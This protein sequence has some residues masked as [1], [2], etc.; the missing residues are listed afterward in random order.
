VVTYRTA[1]RAAGGAT[2]AGSIAEH[3]RVGDDG[4]RAS[5]ADLVAPA[6]RTSE[7][8]VVAAKAWLAAS[9]EG[10]WSGQYEC[11][12]DSLP[13]GTEI[14]PGDAVRVVV[15]SRSAQ[16]DAIV[17]EVQIEIEDLL[18]EREW[19]KLRFAD[20]GADAF[21]L[22]LTRE[23]DGYEWP[24][25]VLDADAPAA[26]ACLDKAQYTAITS[27][28]LTVDVGVAPPAGGG[29]EVRRSDSGWSF[30]ID[31][32]LA[33]RFTTRTFTLPRLARNQQYCFRQYDASNPPRYSR[34]STILYVDL[35]L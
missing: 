12:K 32:N 22:Q 18:G 19:L 35:P 4:V 6:P 15:P 8:C 33:G 34:H 25:V 23:Q 21:A 16:F 20:D 27:T 17:R 31:R 28:T 2:D 5:V 26:L 9:R 14:I 10:G 3:A 7:D 29:I 1:S 13:Q 11:W 30:E 24:R